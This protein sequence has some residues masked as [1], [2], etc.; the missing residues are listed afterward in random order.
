MV[1]FRRGADLQRFLE[2]L[3]PF[4]I[5]LGLGPTRR[6]LERLGNP[7]SRL[8]VFH[9]AGT[10]GKGSTCALL[11]SIL[12]AAGYRVGLYTSPH[13]LDVRERIRVD[14]AM[15]RGSV[16]AQMG[17]RVRNALRRPSPFELTHFEF[18]TVAAFLYFD[19]EEVDFAVIETGMGGRLDATNVV[20]PCVSVL[21]PIGLDHTEWLGRSLEAVAAEKAMIIKPGA[22][23][24]AAE[25][26]V[27]FR[28]RS[29]AC[30][31]PLMVPREGREWR[32]EGGSSLTFRGRRLRSVFSGRSFAGNVVLAVS[33]LEAADLH[34]P[35][36]TI[37][38]GL[39]RC[40][41][42]GR[43]QWVRRRGRPWLLDV[44]HNPH[45]VRALREVFQSRYP[46]KAPVVV[47][48]LLRTK[49]AAGVLAALRPWA[50]S[51]VLTRATDAE[52][53]HEPNTLRALASDLGIPA[54]V[55]P[56]STR[57]FDR[58]GLIAPA[59]D[60]VIVTGSHTLVARAYRHFRIPVPI[61]V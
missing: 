6:A 12:R 42:P 25:P 52:R 9:V 59:K 20:Q 36:E 28:R 10:N 3:D 61:F 18:L 15:I 29:A 34:L 56:D 43:G 26:R 8:K 21:T 38:R 32:Y 16:F 19:S 53:A 4:R 5:R 31:V 27:P 22:P 57:A 7:H 40:C 17:E 49:D 45:A 1:T 50:G 58:S 51:L 37:Q 55:E 41:W 13:F 47:L 33:A 60:P 46:Q 35:W 14:G 54:V 23:A 11:S 39:S 2:G 24:V 48:S 44:A 30:S